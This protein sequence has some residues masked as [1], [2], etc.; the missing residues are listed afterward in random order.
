MN[1]DPSILGYSI[2]LVRTRSQ[3]PSTQGNTPGQTPGGGMMELHLTACLPQASSAFGDAAD[4]KW[5]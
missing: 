4:L 3:F 5:V 1:M 2:Q